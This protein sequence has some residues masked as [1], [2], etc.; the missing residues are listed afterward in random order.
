MQGIAGTVYSQVRE[1]LRT[2]I[3]DGVHL[4]GERLPSERQLA[5]ELD[6]SRG[7]VRLAL[8]QLEREGLIS[9]HE[10]VGYLVGSPRLIYQPAKL[11]TFTSTIGNEGHRP[12]AR[13]VRV[14]EE[15][16]PRDVRERLRLPV[17]ETIH[18]IQRLRLA[19]DQPAIIET[20]YLPSG[21]CPGITD[22][23]LTDRS[24]WDIMT[25]QYGIVLGQAEIDLSLIVLSPSQAEL[26]DVPAGEPAF[27]LT[28]LTFDVA[29]HPIEV[30][31]EIYRGDCTEF[32]IHASA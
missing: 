22:I 32:H 2:R 27:R 24:L 15:L 23:D 6:V 1:Y 9:C 20:V 25:G 30:D 29:N 28:R 14:A 31:E 7:S 12:G 10:R 26:L 3:L 16:P 11:A 13:V 4:P 8:Q 19:S 17:G 21:L 5:T 18:Y